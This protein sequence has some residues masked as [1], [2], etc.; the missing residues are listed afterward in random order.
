MGVITLVY[1]AEGGM[2]AVVVTDAIQSLIMCA[3][4]VVVVVV[5]TTN[6]GNIAA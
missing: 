6:L 2:R 5:V 1:A 4:A 3:E